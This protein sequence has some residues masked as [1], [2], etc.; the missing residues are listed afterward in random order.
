VTPDVLG[1]D[2][3]LPTLTPSEKTDEASARLSAALNEKLPKDFGQVVV[4]KRDQLSAV[5]EGVHLFDRFVIVAVVLSLVFAVAGLW[6]SKRRRRAVVILAAGVALG[7]VLVRRAVF[8]IQHN[9]TNIPPKETG[10]QAAAA[11]LHAFLWPLT[12]FAAWAIGAAV[13][14]MLV[15]YITS[16][17]PRAVAIRRRTRPP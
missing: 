4:Y 3:K 5:Q 2:I 7:M 1:H 13:L 8:R 14:V 15:A 10:R 17:H 9:V 6:L 11:V 12:T 16:G